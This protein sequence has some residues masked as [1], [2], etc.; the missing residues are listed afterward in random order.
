[1][2]SPLARIF[3]CE[4]TPHGAVL[5]RHFLPRMEIVEVRSVALLEDLLVQSPA[6]F[7]VLV[8]TRENCHTMLTALAT[9]VQKHAAAIWTVFTAAG[10]PA[11]RADAFYTAGAQL[12]IPSYAEI[13]LLARLAQRQFRRIAVPGLSLAESIQQQLP[14]S[15]HS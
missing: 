5:L 7:V 8:V 15:P 4:Q 13:P 6:S 11:Q 1:M 3:V 2:K 10:L 9:G 12:L 14:W